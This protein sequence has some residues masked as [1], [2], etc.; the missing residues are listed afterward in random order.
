DI[1]GRK[2]AESRIR[3]QA[4]L[5]N[6]TSDAIMVA[7]LEG[8]YTFWNAGAERITGWSAEEILGRSAEQ[9]FLPDSESQL[10]TARHSVMSTGAW[11][12]ELNLHHKLTRRPAV[13]D[14]R[15]TLVRDDAGRPVAR[16][17]IGTDITE[18]KQLEEQFRRA[19]R[20][21]SIGMLAA[22]IAH[23]L[24]N[25]LA[26]VLMAAPLLRRPTATPAE[27]R[28]LATLEQSA[29]RGAALVQQI[30][31]FARGAGSEQ[32]LIQVPHIA[33]DIAD[34]ITQTFPKSI[35]FE[36]H[37]PADVWSIQAN[38]TQIHQ[39][40]LNFC[41]NARD[42]MPSGGTLRLAARNCV[43]ESASLPAAPGARPGVFLCVEVTDTGTGIPAEK[44][45]Q[46]WEPFYTT[47][48]LGA[49]TGLGLFTCRGIVNTH[50]GFVE[51]RSAVG[52]GTSFHVYLPAV[53]AAVKKDYS[54]APH[55]PRGQGELILVVDDEPAVRELATA[56]LTR[57]GYETL[58]AVDGAEALE[59]FSRRSTE[60]RLV[61]TDLD[62]PNLDGPA[63]AN[64]LGRLGSPVGILFISGGTA[65]QQGKLSLPPG[66]NFLPKPF[67]I[68]D[69]LL[70]VSALLHPAAKTGPRIGLT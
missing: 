67:A 6:Q 15:A 23:D 41:I 57:F 31:G 64:V 35:V 66:A 27:L 52:R 63:L 14:L 28:T 16:L 44:L 59:I 65:A 4:E 1:T 51:V 55:L 17:S 30:L 3:E 56:T 47:K 45:A 24:N 37:L 38:P 32:Q 43:L 36:Q 2:Q 26:P 58:T 8:R 54:T 40:L 33:R 39:L 49:G 60:I 48:S 61:I 18:K 25:I 5:L 34:L 21:E 13:L 11:H 69:L 53:R 12:G 22:G 9:T 62:M 46:I 68:E 19:Q 42:A 20:L 70:R 29:E 10:A 50:R 7:D